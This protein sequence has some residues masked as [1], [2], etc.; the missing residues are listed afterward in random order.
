MCKDWIATGIA[1][2]HS[3]TQRVSCMRPP[4][5]FEQRT[6]CQTSSQPVFQIHV[7][8]PT[9][10]LGRLMPALIRIAC[11]CVQCHPMVRRVGSGAVPPLMVNSTIARALSF[12]WS[13]VKTTWHEDKEGPVHCS[14]HW[15]G[16]CAANVRQLCAKR[17][18]LPP[19]AKTPQ[20]SSP[21]IATQRTPYVVRRSPSCSS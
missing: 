5:H 17:D 1:E 10:C 20:L 2:M 15:R 13:H 21:S 6:G 9:P 11:S 3:A 4:F 8:R 14:E 18:D 16:T 12:C 19:F 7:G